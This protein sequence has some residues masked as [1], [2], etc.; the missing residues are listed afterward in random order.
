MIHMT[1]PVSQDQAVTLEWEVVDLL[2]SDERLL[3][4]MFEDIVAAE[5]P[6]N[7]VAPLR[8]PPGDLGGTAGAEIPGP[9]AVSFAPTQQCRFHCL[10]TDGWARERSPP[11]CSNGRLQRR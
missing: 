1:A 2:L 11:N 6:P 5:W 8:K 10:G 7:P 3:Q 4:E 9:P